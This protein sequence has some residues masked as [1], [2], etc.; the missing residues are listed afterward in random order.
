MSGKRTTEEQEI[1]ASWPKVTAEDIRRMNDL[2]PH[3]LFFRPEKDRTRFW[4]S[5]C[6]RAEFLEHQRRTKLPWENELLSGLKHNEKRACPWCGKSVTMKD[7]RK[8][9]KRHMLRAYEPAVLLHAGEEALYADAVVLA[10]R[11]ETEEGLTAPPDCWLCSMYRFAAGDVMEVD[12]QDWGEGW[13]THERE[14]L[15]RQKLVQEPFKNG[16]ICWFRYEPYVILNRSALKVCPVTRYSGYFALWKPNTQYFSD[17]IS[18]MTAYCIYPRQIEMFVKAGLLEPV[19]ALIEK[20]KKFAEAIRWEEA[21]VRKAMDLTAPELR[22]VIEKKP[23]MAA[24]ELRA[25]AKRWFGQRWTV[26]QTIAYFREWGVD[27]ARYVL[28]FCRRYKLDPQRLTRYLEE[29]CVVDADLPWRDVQDV[30][31]EYRDY[32]EA[33]WNLGLCLEHSRVLWPQDL[34]AAH[35][36]LTAQMERRLITG[37]AGRSDGLV[38]GA[39]RA[40]KY[41]FE[42]DG[43]RIVFPMTAGAIR[44]EGKALKHCVGGYAERHVKGVVTILFLRKADA[45][46]TPYVTI[47]MDGNRIVQ[48]HGFRNDRNGQSPRVIHKGFFNAWL[49]WLKAG[50]RRDKAGKPVLP[51]RKERK[52]A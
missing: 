12:Y 42:L 29:N 4:T 40:K 19:E 15:G 11:Y 1:L 32:L 33:A 7:L 44:R 50:S 52:S 48:V 46:H 34:Q 16:S 35:D 5:C 22:E 31:F 27:D 20:R 8:T 24:L 26:S 23:P 21:D 30:F 2:F 41:S 43:L 13:I 17:F 6:G 39:A 25:L 14:R 10:K 9:G 49:A 51:E 45:L 47:E 36:D 37:T 38:K 3:F 28:T 18:Y